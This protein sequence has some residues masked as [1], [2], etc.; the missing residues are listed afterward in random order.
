MQISAGSQALPLASQVFCLSPR[1]FWCD[2]AFTIYCELLTSEML[3]LGTFGGGK[4]Y[5]HCQ[6]FS[7]FHMRILDVFF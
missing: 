6:R 2:G 4:C 5:P 3:S 7:I 1:T